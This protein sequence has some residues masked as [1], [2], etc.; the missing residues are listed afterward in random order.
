MTQDRNRL[1]LNV[2]RGTA[3]FLMIWG[4][5]IQY[6]AMGSFDVFENTV[7]KFIYSFHMPLFMLISGYLFFF[8]FQKR[9]LK[10]LLVHRTQGMLQPIVMA[11]IFNVALRQLANLFLGAPASFLDGVLL[12]D[13]YSFWFLWCVLSGSIA[14]TLACK[15]TENTLLQMLYLILGTAI[16]A[17]FRE[18]HLHIFMY[19]YFVAGFLFGKY[20]NRIGGVVKR[21]TLVSVLAFPVMLYFCEGKHFIYNT[22]VFGTDLPIEEYIRI[23]LFRWSLGFSGCGF[24]MLLI[25]GFLN[26]AE[27]KKCFRHLIRGACILGENSL[28][29]YCL[30]VVLLSGFLPILQEKAA[31]IL[32][33]GFFLGNMGVYNFVYTPA[34][35]LAYGFLLYGAVLLLKK[36][37]LHK[38][39]FGR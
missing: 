22:P 37:K 26:F 8:S 3:V 31:E 18:M 6:C 2:V 1:Y 34:L 39:L 36:L 25:K 20:Q 14:V 23:N 27:S 13:L 16:V 24:V 9:S 35:S 17:L 28:A 30:S 38:I 29:I 32:D 33:L 12:W 11:S 15:T 5:C 21:L 19:P 4:H 7:F 10:E